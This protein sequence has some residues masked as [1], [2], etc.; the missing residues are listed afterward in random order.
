MLIAC[1][2]KMNI[3]IELYRTTK[4]ENAL[5]IVFIYAQVSSRQEGRQDRVAQSYKESTVYKYIPRHFHIISF[6]Q[7]VFCKQKG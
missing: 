4:H 3:E 7:V 2:V 1:R 6:E 5:C